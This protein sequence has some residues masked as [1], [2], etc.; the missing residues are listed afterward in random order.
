MSIAGSC[1]IILKKD[2]HLGFLFFISAQL[3]NIE[4]KLNK[5]H[6]N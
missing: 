6:E 4:L 5:K 2:Y 1:I 3:I